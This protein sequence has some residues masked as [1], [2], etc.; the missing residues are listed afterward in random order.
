MNVN[1]RDLLLSVIIIVAL[2]FGG[3]QFKA[4]SLK[5]KTF[6]AQGVEFNLQGVMPHTK[7]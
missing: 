3:V 2:V 1:L 6:E 7:Q 4:D 5:F